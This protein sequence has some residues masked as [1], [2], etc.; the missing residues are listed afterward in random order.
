M[1]TARLLLG[2]D[3][4]CSGGRRVAAFLD[5][6][7]LRLAVARSQVEDVAEKSKVPELPKN[8]LKKIAIESSNSPND[9]RIGRRSWKSLA[10]LT[11]TLED[12]G[13]GN[14][15]FTVVAMVVGCRGFRPCEGFA[16]IG[17]DLQLFA[18]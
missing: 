11:E 5:G 9:G 10:E 2:T 18:L 4:A 13:E 16:G 7:R 14:R 8:G 1:V 6:A 3:E 15:Q 12:V 17:Q